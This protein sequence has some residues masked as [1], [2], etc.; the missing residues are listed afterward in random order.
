M[1]VYAVHEIYAYPNIL[2]DGSTL[3]NRAEHHVRPGKDRG[4]CCTT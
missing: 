3:K 4:E 2:P 1:R